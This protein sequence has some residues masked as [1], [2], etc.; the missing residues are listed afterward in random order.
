[1][2]HVK[3][4]DAR[5]TDFLHGHFLEAFHDLRGIGGA[6]CP[7][8]ND[9]E[10]GTHLVG[11]DDLIKLRFIDLLSGI[12]HDGGDGKLDKLSDFLVES[13]ALQGL[14]D[15]GFNLGVFRDGWSAVRSVSVPGSAS[16][17]NGD[18]GRPGED[19]LHNGFHNNG[20]LVFSH[21]LTHWL[22]VLYY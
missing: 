19:S 10:D 18:S 9:I 22:S 15:I 6:M 13:H 2:D 17:D 21:V 4:V 12:I 7:V 11:S 14:F 20:N 1:M 8:V 3:A 5:D 16:G